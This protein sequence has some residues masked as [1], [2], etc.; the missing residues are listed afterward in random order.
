MRILGILTL[1]LFIIGSCTKGKTMRSQ[2]APITS[3]D[4]P[5][6]GHVNEPIL[7]SIN[8]VV[9]DGCGRFGK[10]IEDVDGTTRTIEIEAYYDP[11][12]FCTHYPTT[13]KAEY[14]F[15]TDTPGF[16]KLKF[17]TSQ[18]QFIIEKLTILE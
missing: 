12:G 15:L 17:K 14:E 9:S 3:I 11:N 5:M 16:Y 13:I 8:F 10:L 7:I 6:S 1:T 18:S 2:L 4:V